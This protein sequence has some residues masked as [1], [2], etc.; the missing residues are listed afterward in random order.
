MAIAG[1][2]E[3]DKDTKEQC[4][5][6]RLSLGPLRQSNETR[7]PREPA[8]D[9]FKLYPSCSS[10]IFAT[11]SAPPGLCMVLAQF[12]LPEPALRSSEQLWPLALV[13]GFVPVLRRI[14]PCYHSSLWWWAMMEE[15]E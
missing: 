5:N 10:L 3:Q 8:S 9:R 1:H 12:H 14:C 11:T 7:S 4:P 13:K 15:R 2:G 6:I